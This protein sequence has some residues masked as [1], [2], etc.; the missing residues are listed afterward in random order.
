[1]GRSQ[2]RLNRIAAVVA[3]TFSVGFTVPAVAQTDERT[4]EELLADFEHFML[5]ANYELAE[6]V[7]V[8]LIDRGLSPVE[9][10]ELV[11]GGR[12]IRRYEQAL[13]R[14]MNVPALEDLAASLDRLYRQGRLDRSRNPDEIARNIGLLTGTLRQQQIARERLVAAGEYALPQLLDAAIQRE[15]PELRARVIG[16][17]RDL[18]RQSII[19]LV[20]AIPQ[21]D[22]A[23]QEMVADILG[24]I[25]YR[26]SLPFLLELHQSTNSAPVREAARRAIE[27]REGR[28]DA[29]AA[30]MYRSLAEGYYDERIELTSFAEESHQ[31][32]WRYDAGLGLVMIPIRT[33]VFHE[34]M[35]MDLAE[36]SMKLNPSDRATLALWLASNFSR[37]IDSPAEYQNPAYPNT[38]R[39][40]MYYAV[41]AGP[42][43]SQLVLARAIDKS[44]T[45]LA[46]LAIASIAETAGSDSLISLGEGTEARSPLLEA[47]RYP[48]RRVRYEAALALGKSQPLQ[49]F[50]GAN[51][52][53][54]ILASAVRDAARRT[55]L[56]ATGPDREE[57]DRL[58]NHLEKL[59]FSVLPPA[60]SGLADIA[61]PIAD[62]PAVDIIVTS[63]SGDSTRSVI[64]QSRANSKL[65]VTP[66]LA[67]LSGEDLEPTRR[68]YMRDT[69]VEARRRA[70]STEALTQAINDVI[71]VGSGGLI[72]DAEATAYATRS[73]GVLRDLAVSRNPVLA[74]NDASAT[75]IAALSEKSGSTRLDVAEV[76]S[77]IGRGEAQVA[78]VDAS[79]RAQGSEQIAL[80]GKVSQSAKRH[81]NLLPERQVSRVV[82]LSN[83]SDF[84][85]AT[86]AAALMGALELP[87]AG[88]V[89]MILRDG[90]HNNARAGR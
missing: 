18:G 53:V 66:V 50:E 68:V 35:A 16:V 64:E 11:E 72:S 5:I 80:L 71:E 41:A 60:D 3:L 20:T 44:D 69:L 23:R 38:R 54:P 8:E 89:P 70:I 61:G 56:V 12:N 55:A 2:G 33:E 39:E 57:Y 21:L 90:G 17:L 51:R 43:V 13:A 15:N 62:A 1:M 25:P 31:L 19:P 81:G 88:V 63:L 76:L 65:M 36:R 73:L 32:I 24:Q 46:R 30:E 28:V 74:I 87:N 82:D 79:L 67:L 4:N 42:M 14:A 75:L 59:G 48:D 58:R 29:S 40:A 27:R 77:H 26:T 10:V 37:E 49:N 7:G 22:A 84:Q 85:V 9:Y 78:L 45:N 6:A 34:A 83:S 52:V 47:L 86:A